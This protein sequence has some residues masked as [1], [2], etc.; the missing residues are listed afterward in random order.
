[1]EK[2]ADIVHTLFVFSMTIVSHVQRKYARTGDNL[3]WGPQEKENKTST[4]RTASEFN[5]Q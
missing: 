3:A 4:V 2:P 1:M 5:S